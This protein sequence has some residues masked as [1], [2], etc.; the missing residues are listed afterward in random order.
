MMP[1]MGGCSVSSRSKVGVESVFDGVAVALGGSLAGDAAGVH[2]AGG[3]VGVAQGPGPAVVAGFGE[4][5]AA[6]FGGWFH[7]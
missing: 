4:L 5:G 7:V 2:G 6:A 1:L 3:R